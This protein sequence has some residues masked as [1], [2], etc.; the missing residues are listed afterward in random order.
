METT[1]SGNVGRSNLPRESASQQAARE[2]DPTP[3]MRRSSEVSRVESTSS[4]VLRS[5]TRRSRSSAADTRPEPEID[6]PAEIKVSMSAIREE[7]LGATGPHIPETASQYVTADKPET[8]AAFPIS[9]EIV[10]ESNSSLA[11]NQIV[12]VTN[13]DKVSCYK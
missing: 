7:G 12:L 9:Q 10:V 11:A 6:N 13:E 3:V 4:I 1:S 5:H 8:T 2:T